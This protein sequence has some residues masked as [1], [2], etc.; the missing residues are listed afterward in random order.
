LLLLFP[1]TSYRIDAFVEASKALDLDL[2]LGT[3]LPA[4]AARF[5]VPVVRVEF[6]SAQR[7][8]EQLSRADQQL[9]GVLA[10][11]ERSAQLAARLAQALC[12]EACFHEVAGVQAAADK[13]LMRSRLSEADVLVPRYRVLAAG[14]VSSKLDT[15]QFPCVVK[16]P[17][18]SGSQGVLRADDGDQ[19]AAAVARVRGILERHP[20]E[21]RQ[22]PGFFELIIEDYIEGDELA[23]EGLMHRG[24]LQLYAIFDKPDVLSG[25]TFEETIYVT[26]SRHPLALQQAVVRAAERAAVVLGLCHG[27]IHAELRLGPGGPVLIEIAGRSIGGLCS[28]V[29]A[30]LLGPEGLETRLLRNAIGQPP[31]PLPTPRV[32]ASGVM[33]IPVPRSGV[34]RSVEGLEQARAVAGVEAVTI[35]AQPGEAIRKLPEGASYLGFIFAH[36]ATPEVV[37]QTL[38]RAHG[39]LSFDLKPLLDTFL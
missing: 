22:Q 36:G 15:V 17:M 35:A 2:I 26:P 18:L 27:P 1:A 3:N 7:T 33:M 14:Q 5:G 13:R 12:K 6:D 34:L 23:V 37:E 9:E 32:E 4:A 19:L 11:D 20:S 8:L 31:P 21:L 10:V 38:R 28:R 39:Q 24:S 30:R 16:P 25:P 29:L